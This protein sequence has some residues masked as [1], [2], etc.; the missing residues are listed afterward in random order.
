MDVTHALLDSWDR[1]CRI[2]R[3]LASRIDES[4]R[5]VKPSEDG[6]ALGHQL[7]HLHKSRHYWLSQIDPERAALM[8]DGY[9]GAW[10]APVADLETVK[11]LLDQSAQAIRDA[12]AEAIARGAGRVGGYDNPVLF[13][14]HMLWHEGWHA[15]LIFLGLRLN[16]QEPSGE[17]EEANVWGHWRSEG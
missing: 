7:A 8:D 5:L 10:V 13:L 3:A 1:Q 2:V 4:N 15:G 17:W 14:Q 9:G 16:G 11:G 12:V 6:M